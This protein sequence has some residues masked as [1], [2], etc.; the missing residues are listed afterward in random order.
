MG[1]Y[2][3]NTAYLILFIKSAHGCYRTW[4]IFGPTVPTSAS[5]RLLSF[6]CYCTSCNKQYKTRNHHTPVK[7][8]YLVVQWYTATRSAIQQQ[9]SVINQCCWDIYKLWVEKRKKYIY[10]Y[11]KM[12]VSKWKLIGVKV[13]SAL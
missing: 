1:H 13:N 11:Y 2:K 12:R 9:I 7:T 8:G 6:Q 4:K 5:R 10:I 3:P